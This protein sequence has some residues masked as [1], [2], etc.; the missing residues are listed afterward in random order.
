MISYFILFKPC[1][2]NYVVIYFQDSYLLNLLLQVIA[3]FYHA[4]HCNVLRLHVVYEFVRNP[5]IFCRV[6]L[7][8]RQAMQ[9]E[10]AL[11]IFYMLFLD[12]NIF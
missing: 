2:L 8:Y 3:V 11:E 6:D 12:N 4:V 5:K 9:I 7:E 1:H 10:T